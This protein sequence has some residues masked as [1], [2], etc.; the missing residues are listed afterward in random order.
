M[1]FPAA[2]VYM[3]KIAWALRSPPGGITASP[4]QNVRPAAEAKGV[5]PTN[6]VPPRRTGNGTR[7]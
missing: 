4:Q 2:A 1:F 7:R 5:K 3:D 6:I